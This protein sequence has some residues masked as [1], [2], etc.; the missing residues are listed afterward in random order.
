MSEAIFTMANTTVFIIGFPRNRARQIRT[1][2]EEVLYPGQKSGLRTVIFS[3]E[4]KLCG[5]EG[6]APYLIVRNSTFG[7]AR[8]TA[9]KL[10]EYFMTI[11]VAFEQADGILIGGYPVPLA[12]MR[13]SRGDQ[14]SLQQ[15]EAAG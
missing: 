8:L 1:E 15:Q 10:H 12:A 2:I 7:C 4:T 3:A 11:D 6:D 13:N 14:N 9:G 5:I